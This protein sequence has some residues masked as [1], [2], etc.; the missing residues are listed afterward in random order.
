M[1]FLEIRPMR[2]SL[3]GDGLLLGTLVPRKLEDSLAVRARWLVGAG[4]IGVGQEEELEVT[5]I[6]LVDQVHAED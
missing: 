2:D 3:R 1:C 6:V 4:S 5:G